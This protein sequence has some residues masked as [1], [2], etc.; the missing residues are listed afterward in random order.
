MVL[1]YRIENQVYESWNTNEPV[2]HDQPYS[3]TKSGTVVEKSDKMVE[4]IEKKM[5]PCHFHVFWPHKFKF[6]FFSIT[7]FW[8]YPWLLIAAF[9]FFQYPCL[10]WK[11]K[12]SVMNSSTDILSS[13][14]SKVENIWSIKI[15]RRFGII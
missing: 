9:I 8:N 15:S 10:H 6:W 2:T 12:L 3:Y 1:Q 7:Y 5:A 13:F 11:D 4:K 14:G